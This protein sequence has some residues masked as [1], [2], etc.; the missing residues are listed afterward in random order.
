MARL[1]TSMRVVQ[2]G[3]ADHAQQCLACRRI[4]DLPGNAATT[5]GLRCEP[6]HSALARGTEGPQ[7]DRTLHLPT[8]VIQGVQTPDRS[9]WDWGGNGEPSAANAAACP[10]AA[11]SA[12]ASQRKINNF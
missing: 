5:T 10:A 2:V 12:S 6:C 7:R 8:S 11:C 1:P 3:L 4:D 9:G